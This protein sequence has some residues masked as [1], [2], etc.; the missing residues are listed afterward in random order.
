MGRHQY[1]DSLREKKDE[2]LEIIF[3]VDQKIYKI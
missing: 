1:V 3:L 2:V